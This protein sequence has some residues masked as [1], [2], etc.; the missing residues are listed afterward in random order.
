MIFMVYKKLPLSKFLIMRAFPVF[1]G[2]AAIGLSFS[3][4]KPFFILPRPLATSMFLTYGFGM[5]FLA[6]A[7]DRFDG[8]LN[9]LLGALSI[10]IFVGR[11]LS[12]VEPA[13]Y[14]WHGY[15]GPIFLYY[16][17]SIVH[18]LYHMIRAVIASD[19]DVKY[20]LKGGV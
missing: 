1:A 14:D 13:Y 19:D 9:R 12:L 20:L 17:V 18:F 5:L 16:S 8:M 3:E 10:A 4:I 11:A 15:I 6:I 7:G 2:L